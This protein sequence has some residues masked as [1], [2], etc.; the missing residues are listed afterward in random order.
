[1]RKV[2]LNLAVSLDGFIEGP[3]GE[4][5]WC[6]NDQDYGMAEFFFDTNT[7]FIGRK[8]YELVAGLED[9]YFPGIDKVCVFSDTIT[10]AMHPKV[11]I[12]SS[13]NFDERVNQI[14][15]DDEGGQVWLFGGANL[16]NTFLEKR[17]VAEMLLSVHPVI[18][19]GGKPLFQQ[20]QNRVNLLLAGTQ[21]FDS[22]L[23]QLRY[24]LRPEFDY[25][26]LD[27]T[28]TNPEL[29]GF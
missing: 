25:S 10:D 28:F 9:Q 3:N 8:S 22:G 17:L 5:D 29:N 12:I 18:L 26:M 14:L 6:L 1:M 20:L 16:L 13:K 19:G 11:E 27:A 15:A 7:V 2:I 4:F 23:V 24:T 21:A